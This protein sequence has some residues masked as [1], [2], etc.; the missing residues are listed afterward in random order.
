MQGREGGREEGREGMRRTYFGAEG[1][2][3]GLA[4]VDRGRVAI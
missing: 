1:N 2:D 3:V 4:R